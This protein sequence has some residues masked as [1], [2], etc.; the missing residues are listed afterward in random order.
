VSRT[1]ARVT[2]A[3][4]AREQPQSVVY[5]VEIGKHIKIGFTTNLKQRLKSF[6]TSSPDVDLLL[7]IPGNRDLERTLHEKLSDCRIERELFRQEYRVTEFI[8]NFNYGGLERG[9]RFLEVTDPTTRARRKAEDHSRR[10]AAARQSRAEKD[11]YF[12]S[13]VADRKNRLG[14]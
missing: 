14:W 4:V 5:F 6:R 8:T 10:V 3:D 11:A 9:L 7:A 1:P 2:Q 13:I 12:A